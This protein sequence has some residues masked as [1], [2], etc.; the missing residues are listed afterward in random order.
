MTEPEYSNAFV[1]SI[2][3]RVYRVQQNGEY[4]HTIS[5]EGVTVGKYKSK[6]RAD[7]HAIQGCPCRQNHHY[8]S[9]AAHENLDKEEIS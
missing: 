3:G 6:W 1:N 9:G 4:F 5:P 8:Y 7:N 2:D